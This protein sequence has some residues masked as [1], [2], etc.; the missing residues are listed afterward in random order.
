MLANLTLNKRMKTPLLLAEVLSFGLM[1]GCASKASDSTNANVVAPSQPQPAAPVI[2]SPSSQ[3]TNAA[4]PLDVNDISFLWPVPKTKEDADA[5]I[6][7]ADSASDG[8][9]MP[10][11]I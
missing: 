7:L 1:P 10:P 5:L 11:A 6:S 8:P 3:T 4:E 9:I 2:D